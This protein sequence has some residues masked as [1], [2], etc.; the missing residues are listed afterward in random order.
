MKRRQRL[1]LSSSILDERLAWWVK[2]N[3][4]TSGG[5]GVASFGIIQPDSGSNLVATIDGD[6]ASVTSSSIAV[7]GD[8]GSNELSLEVQNIDASVIQSGTL[9]IA[10][11]GTGLSSVGTAG[12]LLRVDGA[13]TGLEYWTADFNASVITAGTLAVARGGTGLGTFAQGDLLY[14][15]AANTLA[16]LGIGSANQQLRVNAGGTAPE[17]FTP[18]G[19][20]SGD[21]V[22]PA[23]STNNRLAIFDSTT[24]KLLKDSSS[25]TAASGALA[26]V[27]SISAPA[28]SALSLFD[29]GS[30]IPTY[31][32]SAG[33]VHIG[34]NDLDLTINLGAS[35]AAAGT[36]T[37]CTIT[38]LYNGSSGTPRNLFVYGG[39][40]SPT[41]SSNAADATF[42]AGHTRATTTSGR[43]GDLYLGAGNQAN[44]AGT[45]RAGDIFYDPGTIASGGTGIPGM[46]VFSGKIG[47]TGVHRET[48]STSLTIPNNVSVVIADYGS[49]QASATYTLPASTALK[50][51]QT[52]Y[53]GSGTNGITAL[54]LSAGS[55]TSIVG[56]LTTLVA[57]TVARYIYLTATTTWYRIG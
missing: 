55:G 57:G 2:Q 46:N 11:G 4:F 16:A 22:G 49:L 14:A 7:V 34:R 24:G 37:S 48:S 47:F 27:S 8:G 32:Q 43:G 17:W 56:A 42:R 33:T 39:L 6:L 13:G 19:G 3:F 35:A 53:F 54:T 26:G 51:G 20:G 31:Y 40:A 52:I 30:G 21:V 28:A 15:S 25:I 50:N 10:R 29:N 41:A 12:Q 23:S 5:G 38:T 18:S 45:G 36:S 9:G 44:T 1:E